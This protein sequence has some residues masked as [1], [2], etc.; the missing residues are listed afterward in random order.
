[1]IQ[2]VLAVDLDGTLL[3][4]EPE[5]IA[6]WGRTRYQYLSQSAANKLAEI[7]QVLPVVIATA[8]HAQ[9]VKS[10][11]DQ[12]P[13]TNF[14]GFVLENGLVVKKNLNQPSVA[15]NSF[16]T[17]ARLLPE[18]SRIEGY[19]NCLGLIPPSSIANPQEK[20]EQILSNWRI[21]AYVYLD[22][23]KLFVYPAMPS[24]L[25]GLQVLNCVPTMAMGNDW[26][27]LDMLRASPHPLTVSNAY[28]K[29][30]DLISENRGY[31]SP[32]VS[33]AAT[34]DLLARAIFR[35]NNSEKCLTL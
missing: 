23:H 24:K 10:L 2:E 4:P 32:F 3:H 21:Q 7:S 25:S 33:H 35:L 1:M 20:V 11:V 17:I 5:E 19:E 28:I 16:E 13:V 15:N 6:V 14:F 22:G 26:N 34:E 12:L 31:C 9:T 27:D 18:W 8:R 30:K 29:I